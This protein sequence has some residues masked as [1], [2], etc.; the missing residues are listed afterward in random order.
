MTADKRFLGQPKDF[1][2]HIRSIS[3]RAHYSVRGQD[4]VKAP[5]IADIVKAFKDLGLRTDHVTVNDKPTGYGKLIEAYFQ[6]RANV[7]NEYVKVR[8]MDAKRAK[9]VFDTLC[10]QHKPAG[11]DIPMNKQKG[12]KRK[13]NYLQAIINILIRVNCGNLKANLTPRSLTTITRDGKP[14]R[15]LARWIDGAFPDTVNPIAVWEVKEHYHTTTFGSRVSG[16]IYETLL[17]GMEL[18]ELR[19]NEGV[20]VKHYLMV[21]AY[22][23]W[24]GKGRSYLCRII[25]MLHMGLLDEALFGYEVVE[26]MPVIVKEWLTIYND[27]EVGKPIGAVDPGTKPAG[28]GNEPKPK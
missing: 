10:A 15:T 9:R 23:N 11:C 4:R 16:A 28:A 6:Y 17:D 8:L 2:A 14:V 24:W 3:E 1:W 20:D 25:D 18:E 21:D 19:V 7:L 27:R 5:A 22:Q 13:P 26:R 12:K